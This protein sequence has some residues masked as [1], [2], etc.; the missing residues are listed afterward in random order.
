MSGGTLEIC[1]VGYDQVV[2][3]LVLGGRETGIE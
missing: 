1:S 3:V 2:K